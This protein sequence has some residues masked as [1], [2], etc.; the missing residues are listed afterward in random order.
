MIIKGV[1]FWTLYSGGNSC[2]NKALFMKQKCQIQMG[3]GQYKDAVTP[4]RTR[5]N[6]ITL[7]YFQI[8][9]VTFFYI[10]QDLKD[11]YHCFWLVNICNVALHIAYQKDGILEHTKMTPTRSLVFSLLSRDNVR[12]KCVAFVCSVFFPSSAFHKRLP[13]VHGH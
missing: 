1:I 3:V 10:G 4:L 12:D 13:L 2:C 8:R 9:Y 11:M 6:D 5:D 7:Q